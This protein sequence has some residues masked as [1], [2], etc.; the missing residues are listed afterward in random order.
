MSTT[1]TLSKRVGSKKYE[2]IEVILE[3][4]TEATLKEIL[5]HLYDIG[6]TNDYSVVK[7]D[8]K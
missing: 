4:N 8:R 7:I 6:Y 3:L 1:V 2:Y 5:T